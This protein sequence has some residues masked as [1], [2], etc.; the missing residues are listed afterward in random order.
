VS[1]QFRAAVAILPKSRHALSA[2]P[3]GLPRLLV[4]YRRGAHGPRR[5]AW[6]A[7]AIAGTFNMRVR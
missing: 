7:F 3:L 5:S 6:F 1:P 4:R 2:E